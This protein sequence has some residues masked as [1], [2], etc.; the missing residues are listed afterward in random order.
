MTHTQVAT[1]ERRTMMTAT[2]PEIEAMIVSLD[3]TGQFIG[4]G[5]G[6]DLGDG[7]W[8]VPLVFR[9]PGATSQ[10]LTLAPRR[11]QPLPDVARVVFRDR[12][13]ARPLWRRRWPYVTGGVT[14]VLGGLGWVAWTIGGV[15]ALYGTTILGGAFVVGI[16]LAVGRSS[17][18]GHLCIRP[19]CRH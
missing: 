17:A 3:Q 19:D 12:P 16:L 1:R 6:T 8:K 11:R 15:I 4:A 5:Q 10:E 18:S 9:E 14:V 7:L 13:A 2:R